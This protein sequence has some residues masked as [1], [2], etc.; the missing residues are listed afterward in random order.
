MRALW[1]APEP[2]AP[3]SPESASDPSELCAYCK[4]P[5]GNE[6]AFGDSGRL[7]LH[8][9]CEEPWIENLMAEDGVLARGGPWRAPRQAGLAS[10]VALREARQ[11]RLPIITGVTTMTDDPNAARR[12]AKEE[13]RENVRFMRALGVETELV[14]STAAVTATSPAGPTAM[15][16][17]CSFPS[18]SA[19]AVT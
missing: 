9:Q 17:G 7:R 3:R 11:G 8:R 13:L 15:A 1:H 14:F 18:P 2:C 19:P 5:G 6:V 10:S 4:R 16:R 12:A